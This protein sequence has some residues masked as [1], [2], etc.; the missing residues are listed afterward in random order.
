MQLVGLQTMNLLSRLSELAVHLRISSITKL[1]QKTTKA[2]NRFCYFA[3]V[4]FKGMHQVMGYG[5]AQKMRL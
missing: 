4:V 5:I 1:I 3:N 2:H